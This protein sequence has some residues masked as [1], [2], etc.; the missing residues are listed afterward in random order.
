MLYLQAGL[1]LVEDSRVIQR[2][3]EQ[4]G[5]DGI[6]CPFDGMIGGVSIYQRIVGSGEREPRLGITR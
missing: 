4:K 3:A 5:C 2:C 1:G 6:E